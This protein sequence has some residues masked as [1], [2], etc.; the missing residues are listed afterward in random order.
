MKRPLLTL[1]LSA[2]LA[3][4][5]RAGTVQLTDGSS[6]S[7]EIT[8]LENG[9]VVVKTGAGDVTVAKAKIKTLV[10]DGTASSA[11]TAEGDMSYVNKVLDRR[12]KF[13]NDDG[14]PHT[15]MTAMNH[16][17]FSLGLLSYSGDG[18]NISSGGSTYVATSDFNG[19]HYGLDFGQSFNDISGW[20]VFTGFS[21]GE[22]SVVVSTG[23]AAAKAIVQRVDL[24]YLF[25]VQKAIPLGAVES[26]MHLIPHLGLGPLY[27]YLNYSA[28]GINPGPPVVTSSQTRASSAIGGA[29]SLGADLQIGSVL[30]GAKLRYLLSQDVTG[31]FN[32]ANMS[33]MLPQFTVGW[34]F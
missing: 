16:L 29:L 19:L 9:D 15:S 17:G 8:E 32:S 11:G 3:L 31:G 7:G 14:I 4:Q 34:A 1:M 33:A 12:A 5:L 30:V 20:E 6:L 13:G 2:L 10:K 18:L 21:Q 23:T 22:K 25:R 24:A 28:F 27:S 26:N